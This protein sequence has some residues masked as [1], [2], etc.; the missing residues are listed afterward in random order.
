M[1]LGAE[2]TAIEPD[3]VSARGRPPVFVLRQRWLGRGGLLAVVLLL[4][5][6]Y[7]DAEIRPVA[8][9]EGLA[10]AWRY[11]VGTA[12][13]PNSGYFPPDLSR[14]PEFGREMLVTIKMALWG[15]ALSVPPALLLAFLGARNVQPSR[16]VYQLARRSM[17]FFRSLN[18]LIVALVFVAAVGLGPFTG[19]LALAVGGIGSLG[20]LL[21]E[22][23]EQVDEGQIEAVRATGA[24]PIQIVTHGFWPQIA[25]LFVSY[26][27]YR[28][29]A[30]VRAA[31]VLGIVGA[32]GIGYYLEE[33]MKMFD[34]HAA[35]TI[36]M[37]II[38]SV[39]VIDTGSAQIRRRLV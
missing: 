16:V 29:E 15:T 34:N 32:G 5:W 35:A 39:F 30:N 23:V 33:S 12:D 1:R 28:F 36:L 4:A 31:T 24:N 13:R 17:D 7:Q 19:V 8:L 18:E 3:R 6:A 10:K 25:P 37:I 9:V 27:L 2:T 20:K 11:V 21:S 38:G 26:A 22:A 14:F